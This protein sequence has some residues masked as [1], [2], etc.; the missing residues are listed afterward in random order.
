MNE[1]K[2]QIKSDT[3]LFCFEEGVL[4]WGLVPSKTDTFE[5][6]DIVGQIF[7]LRDDNNKINDK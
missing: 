3:T 2:V 4:K 6:V 7:F 5:I 1:L